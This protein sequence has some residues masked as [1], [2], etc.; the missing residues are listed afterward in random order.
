MYTAKTGHPL[1]VGQEIKASNLDKND[2]NS[3]LKL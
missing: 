2:Q 3:T 1:T